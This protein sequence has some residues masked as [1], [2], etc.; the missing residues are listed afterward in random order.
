MTRQFVL[1][2][3]MLTIMLGELRAGTPIP[4]RLSEESKACIECHKS[5]DPGIY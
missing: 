3:V 2:G 1:S 5:S 4:A